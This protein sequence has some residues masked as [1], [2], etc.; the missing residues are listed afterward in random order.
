MPRTPSTALRRDTK[1]SSFTT[2]AGAFECPAM[3]LMSNQ[4]FLD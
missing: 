1:G 4:N 2:A 3:L